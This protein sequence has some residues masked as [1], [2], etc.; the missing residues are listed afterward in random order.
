VSHEV[1]QF[2]KLLMDDAYP[3]ECLQLII[4]IL[5]R[6]SLAEIPGIQLFLASLFTDMPRLG[7]Q[8]RARILSAAYLALPGLERVELCWSI[9]DLIARWFPKETSL[10]FF[11]EVSASA[12]PAAM[13]G[14]MLGLDVLRMHHKG[15]R[16]VTNAIALVLQ[17]G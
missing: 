3:D 12:Q 14:V 13:E 7:D 2:E 15:D 9:C 10:Q 5:S 1:T 6:K 16:A 8:Q 11:L 17:K 4:D